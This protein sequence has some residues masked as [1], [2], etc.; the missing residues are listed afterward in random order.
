MTLTLMTNVTFIL[1]FSS[2]YPQAGCNLRVER[3][4]SVVM[5]EVNRIVKLTVVPVRWWRSCLRHWATN[6]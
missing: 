6:R 3:Y 4:I 1:L 5:W 2:S